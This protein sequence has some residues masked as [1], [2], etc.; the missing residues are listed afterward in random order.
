MVYARCFEF[1]NCVMNAH[2]SRGY[3]N[4]PYPPGYPY[5]DVLEDV[6]TC[7]R[8]YVNYYAT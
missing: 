5:G 4:R 6:R 3:A 2:A 8:K 7:A 1:V